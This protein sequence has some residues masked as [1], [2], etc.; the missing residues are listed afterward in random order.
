MLLYGIRMP[1]HEQ[2]LQ[3]KDDKEQEEESPQHQNSISKSLQILR[4]SIYSDQTKKV[5]VNAFKMYCRYFDIKDSNYDDLLTFD[6][7]QTVEMIRKFILYLRNERKLSHSRMNLFF[8]ALKLYYEQNDYQ[9]ELS[10][11]KLARFKG[12]NNGKKNQ[13]RTYTREEIQLMLQHSD[14]RM[15]VIILTML[16]SGVRTGGLA[17]VRLKDLTYIE[18]YKLY[19]IVVYSD[20]TNDQYYT[21]ITPECSNYIKL[22][23]EYRRNQGENLVPDSPL[24]RQKFDTAFDPNDIT[25]TSEDIQERMRYL[26]KKVGTIKKSNNNNKT[27]KD[28]G[29][30]EYERIEIRKKRY[31][32]MRCHGFR[33]FFNTICIESDMNIV[34]KE[35]LMGHKQSLGLEKSYYRPTND[36]LLNEY[37]K[38]VNDLTINDEYRLSKQV[39]E[40]KEKDDYQQYV[41]DKKMQE[42]DE[43]IKLLMSKVEKLS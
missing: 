18:Q 42:K 16:S 37:L 32:V 34:S 17:G 20:S 22:Y 2:L 27:R 29:Y 9:F 38:V 14:L 30:T 5:Y 28:N 8:A 40:L 7:N 39:Q 10:W 36:K 24:I 12:K 35:L 33:K 31:E 6:K 43:Q 11:S 41:I 23:L 26:L 21:F 15:K 19:R 1:Y 3:P 25:V 4:D 13:D